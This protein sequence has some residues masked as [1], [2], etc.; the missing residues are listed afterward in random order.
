MD[1]KLNKKVDAYLREYKMNIAK[2]INTLSLNNNE[3]VKELMDYIYNY[4]N[5]VISNDDVTRKKRI[6]NTVPQYERCIAK[7][8]TGEQCTRR[9]KDDHMFC[10][11]HI[12]GTP[13]GVISDDHQCQETVKKVNVWIQEISGIS[14]YIDDNFNV[15]NME[16]II[17]N[18]V[19]PRVV[20]KWRKINDEYIIEQ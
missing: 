9:R 2:K 16:D 1:V 3:T 12:K 19:N 4:E 13:H 11:T 7:R 10:G 14:Y 17:Q 6:K 18:K 15:Y 8:S 5:L 20:Y